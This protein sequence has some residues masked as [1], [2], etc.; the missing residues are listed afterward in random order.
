MTNFYD[1]FYEENQNDLNSFNSEI[2]HF[3]N[4]L[5]EEVK[6]EFLYEMEQLR[7][8][9][10]ELQKVKKN[11]DR[12]KSDYQKELEKEV[13]QLR[14]TRQEVR[15]ERFEEILK[16]VAIPI[17]V[18]GIDKSLAYKP[19]CGHCDNRLIH[20]HSPGGKELTEP[21]SECG[22]R[23]SKWVVVPMERNKIGLRGKRC[24]SI[25]EINHKDW[26]GE[27]E[28]ELRRNQIYEGDINISEE[29]AYR[30]F[31]RDRK[32]FETLEKAQEMCDWLNRDLPDNLEIEKEKQ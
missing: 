10:S 19:L 31:D 21:C 5:R 20:F 1:D 25:Y 3:K 28:W 29:Q 4:L 11:L 9:N 18:Y 32:V 23:F 17:T 13:A 2:E 8:E 16:D 22:Q 27:G 12:I 14:K 6:Q 26:L 30:I 24:W 7:K 15:Q